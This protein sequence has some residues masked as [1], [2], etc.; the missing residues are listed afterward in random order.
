MSSS[1]Y[2]VIM[3]GG[4]GTRLWPLSRKTRPK[5]MLRII[6][7]RSLFQMAVDRLA[8][9]FDPQHILVV[10]VPEQFQDLHEQCPQIPEE[11]FLLEPMPRGTA[12]VVGLAALH[13][14]RL[15]KNAVMAVLTA[16]HYIGN[17]EWFRKLLQVA[18]I[19]ARQDY[20]VTIGINPT[21]A[22]TGYGYIQQGKIQGTYQGVAVY[23]VV[24]FKEKPDEF[25]AQVML[26]RGDH[27]WNSGMFIWKVDRI[28]QEIARQMPQL[29]AALQSIEAHWGKPT[30]SE[31]L[32]REWEALIPE[33]I[34]YG[35]MEGAKD[36]VVI[37]AGALKWSDVGSWDS[38][39]DVLPA[40]AHGNIVMGGR[41]FGLDT[42]QSLVYVSEEHRLIVTIGVRDLVVVDT[43]DVLLIVRK[44]EAQK[45]RQVV[46]FLRESGEDYV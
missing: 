44:D 4:G 28:R 27:T 8:G 34:D 30:Y 6:E 42:R 21:F 16:D 10:T 9:L 24:R 1:Y 45:V 3:A 41:H 26:A 5:Q 25:Q 14:A 38:L 32:A 19:V 39:F 15:D 11:N 22:A 20:L 37:P 7:Q 13:L 35:I 29:E 12:A 33:T 46:E 23:H 43:G 36:V 18:E 17:Q 2:A 31:V 40:D